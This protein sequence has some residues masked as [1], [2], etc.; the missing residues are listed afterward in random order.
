MRQSDLWCSKCAC[1]AGGQRCCSSAVRGP[2]PP[3]KKPSRDARGQQRLL[4]VVSSACYI[5]RSL[6]RSKCCACVAGDAY[7]LQAGTRPRQK[8]A[9][10]FPT[11][12]FCLLWRSTG[13]RGF[14]SFLSGGRGE[15]HHA[16]N[17]KH[18]RSS[19]ELMQGFR[20]SSRSQTT[21]RRGEEASVSRPV[22]CYVTRLPF[23]CLPFLRSRRV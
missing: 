2:T 20:M 17:V 8:G 9:P 18:V 16:H 14:C 1:Q 4:P 19:I 15:Q 5:G 12:D 7:C 23:H 10:L 22:S 21:I 3:R 6:M 13:A 11:G